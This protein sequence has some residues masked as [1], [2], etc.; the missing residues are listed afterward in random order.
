MSQDSEEDIDDIEYEEDDDQENEFVLDDENAGL[1]DDM[2]EE[3]E[4]V[5][6]TMFEGGF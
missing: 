3:G 2:S 5:S 6:L 4:D 1:L